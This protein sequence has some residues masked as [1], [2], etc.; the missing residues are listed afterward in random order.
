MSLDL[1]IVVARVVACAALA[2]LGG[3]G[4]VLGIEEWDVDP[5]AGGGPATATSSASVGEGPASTVGAGGDGP[6]A[7]GRGEGGDGGAAA[8]TTT[9]TGG[10][11]DGGCGVPDTSEHCGAC[12]RS[13]WG[14][15]CN[16]GGVCGPV[17]VAPVSAQTDLLAAG[18]DH[19]VFLDSGAALRRVRKSTPGGAVDVLSGVPGNVTSLT[20][21]DVGGQFAAFHA[22]DG[23]VTRH[24][25]DVADPTPLSPLEDDRFYPAGLH[26]A[27]GFIY[28]F[29]ATTSEQQGVYRSSWNAAGA[30]AIHCSA[31]GAMDLSMIGPTAY[32]VR[33]AST[34]RQLLVC[35]GSGSSDFVATPGHLPYRVA[36]DGAAGMVY[37]TTFA[38]PAVEPPVPAAIWRKPAAGGASELV[39]A[40]EAADT[41]L[42]LAVSGAHV[43]WRTS[44]G[45]LVAFPKAGGALER[46]AAGGVNAVAADAEGV[47]WSNQAGVWALRRDTP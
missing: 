19:I 25:L 21:S 4:E 11:G 37:Y 44:P 40:P 7:G 41:V 5:G 14:G 35:S 1:R 27:A 17:Q 24:L 34:T 13:C 20:V 36:A 9:T 2:S 33:M 29:D 45:E 10:G 46:I 30:P 12:D 32:F 18:G 6:G 22:S 38:N 16:A 3:C 28:W 26:G 15:P 47:Y 23:R 39:L 8:V 42:R 43:Y 31:S